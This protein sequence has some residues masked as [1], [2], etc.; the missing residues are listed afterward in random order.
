VRRALLLLALAPVLAGCG[1]NGVLLQDPHALS[2]VSPQRYA[3]VRLPVTL[4]W[5]VDKAWVAS[6]GGTGGA[7]AMLFVDR[8][9]MA[10]GE[11]FQ[12]ATPTDRSGV[13]DAVGM[14]YTLASLPAGS[15]NAR[16]R[17]EVT[18]VLVDRSGHRL[19]EVSDYLQLQVVRQ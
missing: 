7:H 15:E 3:T 17:H 11:V 9:P 8:S 10:P 4:R 14:T 19:G 1:P 13:V 6:A 12:G 5:T 16:G 18:V 2:F